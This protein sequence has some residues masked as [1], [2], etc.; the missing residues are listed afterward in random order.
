MYSSLISPPGGAEGDRILQQME[1]SLQTDIGVRHQT[2]ENQVKIREFEYKQQAPVYS[3]QL[4]QS[5]TVCLQ[6][7]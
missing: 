1:E 5:T 4:N 3:C 2:I 7:P 6:Y